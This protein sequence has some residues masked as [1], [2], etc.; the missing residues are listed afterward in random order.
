MSTPLNICKLKEYLREHPD[1]GFV[2][3]LVEGFTHGFDTGIKQ[4]PSSTL[5]CKNLLSA[6]SQTE[7]T[8][9]LIKKEFEKGFLAGPYDVMP[10]P[11]YRVNPVGVAEGKYSKKK[12][13]IVDGRVTTSPAATTG[14][15]FRK[16]PAC[17][18]RSLR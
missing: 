16:L 4:L 11:I 9:S 1:Q 8:G 14:P 15:V 13:L 6:R 2:N 5:E 18:H 3:Y 10:Y 7:V 12:R 17:G